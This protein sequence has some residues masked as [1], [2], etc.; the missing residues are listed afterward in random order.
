MGTEESHAHEE[1]FPITGFIGQVLKEAIAD[2][3]H[4][5]EVIKTEAGHTV[6]ISTNGDM[7]EMDVLDEVAYNS[8]VNRIKILTI[9][10]L[11]D[12]KKQIGSWVLEVG[13]ANV[14]IDAE[15]SPGENGKVVL[16][17]SY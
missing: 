4:L 10:K 5:V 17:L 6:S 14:K 7:K 13:G 1:D 11:E 9:M 15:V 8:F 2:R 3:A 16:K 12:E